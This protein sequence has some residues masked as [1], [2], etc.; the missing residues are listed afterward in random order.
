MPQ[1][2]SPA[3]CGSCSVPQLTQHPGALRPRSPLCPLLLSSLHRLLLSLPHSRRSIS[4]RA[5][6]SGH[7]S[8]RALQTPL[9]RRRSLCLEGCAQ[10]PCL[11]TVLLCGST[12][13][14]GCFL[15]RTEVIETAD[16]SD[17]LCNLWS[18][19]VCAIEDTCQWPRCVIPGPQSQARG[20]V[21]SRLTCALLHKE[22]CLHNRQK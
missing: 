5:V 14:L 17:S 18:Q 19:H 9:R 15:S 22:V 21:C 16:G 10:G 6:R 3:F 7:G 8:R 11:A 13:F 20:M 12:D 2:Q 4:A 1:I